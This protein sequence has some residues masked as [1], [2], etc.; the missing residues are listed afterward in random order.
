MKLLFIQ[1]GGEGTHD[2]WDHKL[3]AS[4]EK[5]LDMSVTYPRMPTEDD[6]SYARW[7]P[8]IVAEL[9]KLGDDAIVVGHSIGGTVLA[10][11]LA[12]TQRTV[13][14]LVL[15]AS[16]YIGKDGWPS[17]DVSERTDF[18][19]PTTMRVLLFHGTDDDTAPVAHVQLYAKAIPHASVFVLEGRDHQLNDDLAEVA[20]EL[21]R[22][23]Q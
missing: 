7:K 10:H 5:H 4:L 6:P 12:E 14:T 2:E 17:D 21:R 11:V 15:V 1:G 22:T 9:E 13:R 8:A 20:R 18:G 16:P 3:V 23:A 19:F